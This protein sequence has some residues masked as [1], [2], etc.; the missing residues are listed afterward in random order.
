M[1]RLIG[2]VIRINPD[3]DDL[4]SLKRLNGDYQQCAIFVRVLPDD[5]K[6]TDAEFK[7][8]WENE[9]SAREALIKQ[10]QVLESLRQ[11]PRSRARGWRLP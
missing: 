3:D 8:T 10:V 5:D 1:D 6:R 9:G 7:K 2:R 4:K 11:P